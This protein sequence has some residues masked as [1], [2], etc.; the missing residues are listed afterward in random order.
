MTA[1]SVTAVGAF[2]VVGSILVVA[3][4]IAPPAGAYLIT[5][6]LSNMLWLSGLIAAVSAWGGFWLAAWV[7]ANIAGSMATMSEISSHFKKILREN[8]FSLKLTDH[9]ILGQLPTFGR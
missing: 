2:D 5:D 6:R 9:C 3:L 1:V 8:R 7:D 4:M